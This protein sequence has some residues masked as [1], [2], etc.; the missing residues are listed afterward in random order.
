M[1]GIFDF[2]LSAPYEDRAVA[3]WSNDDESV[4]VDTCKVVDGTL[5]IETGVIHPEYNDGE[6]MIVEAYGSV[7]A[8]LEGHERWVVMAQR[9]ELPAVIA[10]C[11][12]AHCARFAADLSDDAEEAGLVYRR[13][14]VAAAK[15]EIQ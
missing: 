5:P 9:D 2:L 10:D 3:H 11:C 15:E 12:N 4:I 14:T 13:S 6:W 7:E 8:A 1:G